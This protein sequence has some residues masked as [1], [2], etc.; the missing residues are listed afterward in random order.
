MSRSGRIAWWGRE[1]V[2]AALAGMVLMLS[3][4]E[5]SHAGTPNGYPGG[6]SSHGLTGLTIRQERTEFTFHT[7][8]DSIWYVT[9]V[10]FWNPGGARSTSLFLDF[11]DAQ[12]AGA[13]DPSEIS[14]PAVS[15][16]V[17]GRPV[18]P[19]QG[20]SPF[21]YRFGLDSPARRE[22]EVRATALF[23]WERE[24]CASPPFRLGW[25]VSS[26]SVFDVSHAEREVVFR[27][28]PAVSL[29]A[30]R[31]WGDSSVFERGV[32]TWKWRGTAPAFW[33]G[34]EPD[35]ADEYIE[36]FPGRYTIP[37][38]YLW[39]HEYLGYDSSCEIP[40]IDWAG[41]EGYPD[42]MTAEI[43]AWVESYRQDATSVIEAV[44]AHHGVS[45][46]AADSLVSKGLHALNPVEQR[47]LRFALALV[48]ILDVTEKPTTILR[49]ME[50]IWPGR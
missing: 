4:G 36:S 25:R 1:Q 34:Y 31:N 45:P 3:A 42:S 44:C 12:W 13:S 33:I 14:P 43:R 32:L 15:I 40:D 9:R 17:N 5:V 6:F 35:L 10:R 49:K 2:A 11:R 24:D 37:L 20:E 7:R 16:T 47:N 23:R 18:T 30:V 29:M 21:Q 38:C 27:F 39:D 41:R 48:P 8:S 50:A 46:G 22:V 26:D 19:A 28:D